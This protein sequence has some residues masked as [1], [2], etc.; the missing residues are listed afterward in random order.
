MP[1]ALE[2]VGFKAGGFGF[3]H[4]DDPAGRLVDVV[5]FKPFDGAERLNRGAGGR[6]R[7]A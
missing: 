2:D 5:D 6:L 7:R 1:D 4:G 3:D